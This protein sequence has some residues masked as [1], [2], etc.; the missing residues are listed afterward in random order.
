MLL[1]VLGTNLISRAGEIIGAQVAASSELG[2]NIRFLQN[3]E[4]FFKGLCC[5]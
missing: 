5:M 3:S 2:N 1:N 4:N